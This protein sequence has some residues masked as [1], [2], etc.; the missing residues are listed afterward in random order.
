L[1]IKKEGKSVN[2]NLQDKNKLFSV[3]VSKFDI[4]PE[5]EIGEIFM[6]DD[7][8]VLLVG[9][10]QNYWT[11]YKVTEWVEFATNYDFIFEFNGDKWMAI[12]DKLYIPKDR[13]GTYI[14]KIPEKYID[15][16]FEH[17]INDVNIPTQYTGLTVPETAVQYK[18][19]ENELK[20]VAPYIFAQFVAIGEEME[21]M[22]NINIL[23]FNDAKNKIKE[24]INNQT[25]PK[26]A[27]SNKK[28]A[29]GKNFLLSLDKSKNLIYLKL[30]DDD[31]K[32]AKIVKISLFSHTYLFYN[33]N[34]I[35]EIEVFN[36]N[37][38][39]QYIAN[40]LEILSV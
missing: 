28:T 16:L 29:R 17:E 37:I 26:A 9:E 8:M 39:V 18:F 3:E 25:Y 34:S 33:E 11:C 21:N 5:Y 14:G 24:L 35:I 12:L 30:I 31:F 2:I 23:T 1:K 7:F 22:E 6:V 15:V 20:E 40:N 27:H 4:K 10:F 19:R 13:L 38:D 36:D 32:N